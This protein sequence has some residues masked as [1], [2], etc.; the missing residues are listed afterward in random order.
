L[1]CFTID[2]SKF[3][4]SETKYFLHKISPDIKKT[5]LVL[6]R[7]FSLFIIIQN[8]IFSKKQ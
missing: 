5:L 8:A 1:Y 2:Y 4:T 6:G 3:A 7:S